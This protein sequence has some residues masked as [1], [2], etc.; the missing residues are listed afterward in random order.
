MKHPISSLSTRALIL[1][2]CLVASCYREEQ[3][4][5]SAEPENVYSEYSLPQGSHPYDAEILSL[6]E[7]Y[8]TVILYKYQAH[9]IYWNE[10]RSIGAFR[11]D[12]ENPANSSQGYYYTPA[13]EAYIGELLELIKTKFFNH[14][15][16]QEVLR[17]MLPK[18][19][20]L[21]D[22]FGI[23]YLTWSGSIPSGLGMFYALPVY[24]GV[25]YMLFSLGGQRLNALTAAEKNTYKFEAFDKFFA[26]LAALGKLTPPAAFSAS[27]D[28]SN[29]W[30]PAASKGALGVMPNQ[31]GQLTPASDWNA[32]VSVVLRT[33]YD[34][35]LAQPT[36]SATGAPST[37]DFTGYLHPDIDVNGKIREK[38]EILLAYFQDA[39]GVDLQGIG[40]D[41][42]Q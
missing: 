21:A 23:R 7:R 5:R 1:S 17:E 37:S 34:V 3:P 33:P 29:A 32:Y 25:D 39:F 22:T 38:Y 12:S 42:E 11:W 28:Y 9:D 26:K 4:T 10:D 24:M 6:F 36:L 13:D 35:L 27:T 16:R 30:P 18:K 20:F 31:N 41:V 15:S 8:N 40:N 2:C 14:F 19:I